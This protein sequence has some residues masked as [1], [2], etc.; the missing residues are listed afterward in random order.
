M[1]HL[2]KQFLIS[3]LIKMIFCVAIYG[4]IMNDFLFNRQDGIWN[5][6]Y[7]EAGNWELS[8]GR[9]AIPY[10]DITHFGVST[11]PWSTILTLLVLGTCFLVNLFQIKIGSIFDYLVSGLFLGNVVVCSSISYLY[12]SN[13]YGCSFLLAMLSIWLIVKGVENQCNNQQKLR[14]QILYYFSGGICIAVVLGLYQAYL[15]CIALVALLFF[16]FLLY[17]NKPWKYIRSYIVGGCATG[18]GGFIVFEIILKIELLRHNVEMSSYNGADTLSASNIVFNLST[19]IRR[20]YEICFNY[21]CG[22]DET[23]WNLFAGNKLFILVAILCLLMII[24]MILTQKK[25]L[26]TVVGLFAIILLPLAANIVVILVPGSAYQTWQTAP[27]AL[28]I[29]VIACILYKQF[30]EIEFFK[31]KNILKLGLALISIFIMWGSIYQTQIDQEAL[32]QGTVAAKSMAQNILSVLYEKNMYSEEQQYAVIGAPCNNTSIY[33]NKLYDEANSYAKIAGPYWESSLD[34]R[35]W[36]GIFSNLC[37][38]NLPTCSGSD[39]E[40]LLKDSRVKGMTNFP[41]DGSVQ[42]IDGIVV[43]RVS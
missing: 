31:L 33:L 27:C 10:L 20:A 1:K 8:L 32:R 11:H 24:I 17:S 18:I 34:L 6:T 21:F 39:Y 22:V 7:Y 38:V 14:M 9:W 4:L 28:I 2:L 43:I 30:C 3:V 26:N 19:S 37:G 13:I 42:Q 16:V 40:Y 35:T 29:P 25:F 23:K 15:G 5:G 12:T 36:H 41:T